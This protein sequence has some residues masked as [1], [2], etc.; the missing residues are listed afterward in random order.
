M[1]HETTISVQVVSKRNLWYTARMRNPSLDESPR[2]ANLD[3]NTPPQASRPPDHSG[4]R[5][6]SVLPADALRELLRRKPRA[7]RATR[8]G[9]TILSALA[10]IY[11]DFRS[12]GVYPGSHASGYRSG[13]VVYRLGPACPALH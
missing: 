5:F 3:T 11:A 12:L 13:D 7:R 1:R 4:D 8:T 10:Q 6:E 9:E 2:T